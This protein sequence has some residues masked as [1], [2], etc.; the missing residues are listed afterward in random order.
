MFSPLILEWGLYHDSRCLQIT[1]G[2][3]SKETM[4]RRPGTLV[5]TMLLLIGG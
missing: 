2:P 1:R 4:V 3:L 5:R